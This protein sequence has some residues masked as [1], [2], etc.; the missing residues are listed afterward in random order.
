MV[1]CVGLPPWRERLLCNIARSNAS[2][3][4]PLRIDFALREIEHWR[5][6][7]PRE[8]DT[9]LE[10]APMCTLER[11]NAERPVPSG[12][13]FLPRISRGARAN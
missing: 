5:A 2:V 7:Q 9:S 12:V 4:A 3:T 10:R 11:G 8:M 6:L 1:T 13:G